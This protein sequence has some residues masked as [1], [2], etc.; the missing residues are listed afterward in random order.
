M[1][2][3]LNHRPLT[4]VAISL[5]IG[6]TFPIYPAHAVFLACLAAWL[7]NPRSVA[8][9]V[10]AGLVGALLGPL[11]TRPVHGEQWF[12]GDAEVLSFPRAAQEGVSFNVR[13][14]QGNFRARCQSPVWVVPK[15]I[16][17]MQGLMLPPSS[18]GAEASAIAGF[19]GSVRVVQLIPKVPAPAIWRWVAEIRRSYMDWNHQLLPES[20]AA[21][22][23]ALALRGVELSEEDR[24][25]LR[26]SGTVHLV[27]ASGLHAGVI[28]VLLQT[29][30]LVL[31]LPRRALIMVSIV[32]LSVFAM[33]NMLGMPTVRA[34]S[35]TT[36]LLLAPGLR[37]RYDGIS[38]LSLVVILYLLFEPRALYS[39]GFQLSAS[40]V[41]AL[42][43]MLHARVVE[44]SLKQVWLH[45]VQDLF[46]VSVIA[47]VV[48]EP[49]IGC[50]LGSISLTTIPANMI[51]VPLAVWALGL[52]MVGWWSS[53][54][55]SALGAG[56]TTAAGPI[57]YVLRSIVH[58]FGEMPIS[59][60]PAPT[61]SG[62][63][64]AVFLIS[65]SLLSPRLRPQPRPPVREH[66]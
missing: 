58:A 56:V 36:V 17:S 60:L 14:T 48:G 7:W 49:I 39:L 47:A 29:F 66:A 4:V 32:G 15:Q 64:V 25:S 6:L 35:M 20:V 43:L 46:K 44:F 10:A 2:N 23:N 12:V 52:A 31:G 21:W 55:L 38:A 18:A 19:R 28:F 26:K 62:Y 61:G 54:V 65:L 11:P 1:R 50:H 16:V 45:G 34:V 9:V 24:E 40:I 51:G 3:F 42:C 41:A 53:F 22:L 63:V 33:A 8:L 5:V 57:V 59:E 30:S 37:R 13:T 27:A